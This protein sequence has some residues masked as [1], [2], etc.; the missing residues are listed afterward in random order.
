MHSAIRPIMEVDTGGGGA[1]TQ[2]W[3]ISSEVQDARK[4]S[5]L[6]S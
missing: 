3:L 1:V 2:F 4:P 5:A 6:V